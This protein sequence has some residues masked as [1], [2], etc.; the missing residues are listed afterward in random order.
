MEDQAMGQTD[1]KR[2]KA[3][4]SLLA[5]A[6]FIWGVMGALDIN[7]IPYDGY[8]LSPKNTVTNVQLDSPAQQAGLRVGDE[9]TRIDGIPIDDTIRL[10]VR[11]RPAPNSA[12][13][14]TVR[15]GDTEETLSLTYE[16]IPTLNI[17]TVFGAA[18]LTGLL[19]LI[20]GLM[21]YLRNPTRLSAMF[22]ALSLLFAA[23]MFNAPYFQSSVVRRIASGALAIITGILLG[24][25][26][27][28]CLNFPRAKK[29]IADRAWLRL[30]IYSI[31]T[32]LG[33]AL[34]TISIVTPVMTSVRQ[35]ILSLATSLVFGGALLLAVIGVIHSF[36]TSSGEERSATGLSLLLAGVII[37]FGPLLVSIIA[38]IINPEMGALPGEQFYPLSFIAIPIGMAMALMKLEPASERVKAEEGAEA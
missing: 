21:A 26:L 5:I 9:V 24:A 2:F 28:Y 30:T 11:D 19:F 3:V 4:F 22:C 31:T 10:A 18:T 29:I 33:V 6:V 13:T 35:Q 34:A 7:N 12:G 17:V 36:A 25:I 38:R 16:T 14:I 32:S 8:S 27:D 37:G 20:L 15:R 1:Y 23:A